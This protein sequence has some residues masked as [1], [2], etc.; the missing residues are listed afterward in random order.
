MSLLFLFT[1]AIPT[2]LAGIYYGRIASDIFISES[3]FLVRT[4]QRSAGSHFGQLLQN[5]GL[6]RPQDESSAVQDF[7][8]SRDALSRLENEFGLSKSFSS[9]Q[10][11]R[12]SRFGGLDWDCSFEALHRYYQRRVTVNLDSA[13]SILTLRVEAFSPEEA[14]KI[15]CML[16]EM[17]EELINQLNRRSRLDM[18]QFA[19]TEVKQAESR[20]REASIAVSAYR[21]TK[22]IFDPKQQSGLQLQGVSKLQEELISNRTHLAQIQ[23]ASP[24]SPAVPVLQQRIKTLNA[25]IT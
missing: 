16:L 11:D 19:A 12:I 3:H 24:H 2:I 9:Q 10:I 13:S 15:N 22:G 18:I 14:Y 6:S 5:T 25:E 4:P 17:S 8:L 1:V 23:T 7:I 21:N 20:A